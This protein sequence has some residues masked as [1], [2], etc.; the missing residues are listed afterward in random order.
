VGSAQPGSKSLRLLLDT[1]ILLWSLLEPARLGR[2]VAA[3]LED[4]ASELWLSP[5]AVWEVLILA[6]RGRVELE[7]DPITWMRRVLE[8]IPFRQAP[9]THEVAVQ[10]RLVNLPHRD[11]ADRFLAAT[12]VVY[13]LM[14]VTADERLFDI[15]SVSTL[16]SR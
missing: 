12:A 10:S 8:T 13:D 9:L 2:K 15:P 5:I 6:E 3:A 4:P 16:A 1:H 11:P 14:L 7:P